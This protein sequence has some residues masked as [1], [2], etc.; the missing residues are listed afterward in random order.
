[1]LLGIDH[2]VIAVRE[3]D[4]AAE[5]LEREV[6]IA[7]TGGGRH[8]HMG[9]FNRL[10]FL[11]DT[12]VEL[13]GVFD[14]ALVLA[15]EAFAVG[16]AALDLLDTGREGLASYALAT[17]DIGA[18]VARLRSAGSSIGLPV[19][20]SR[21]RPDGELVRWITAFPRLGPD[22]PPFLIEH[23]HRG[24][25]WGDA[26]RAARATFRHP[27]GGRLRLAGL[28]LPVADPA[29]VANLYRET[30]GVEFDPSGHVAIGG[31]AIDLHA[32]NRE[33]TPVLDL[34]AGPGTSGLDLV[35]LGVRWRRTAVLGGDAGV[36]PT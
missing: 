8:E 4:G 14:R 16:R 1:M 3:P 20:G 22:Q 15:S 6:S 12:Y 35:R 36:R 32:G 23:D 29:A 27:Q 19:T 21:L 11:A 18:D 7:F 28:R 17:D 25:E 24:A 10:A 2:V 13:I 33:T 5:A 26:A 9:T 34:A 31:Q 30:V